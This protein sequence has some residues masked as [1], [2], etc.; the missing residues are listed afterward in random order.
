MSVRNITTWIE[1]LTH[2]RDLNRYFDEKICF[3]KTR[4][5]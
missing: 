5:I 2:L 1:T 4:N 3:L